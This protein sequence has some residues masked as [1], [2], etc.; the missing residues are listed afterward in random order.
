MSGRRIKDSEIICC[1]LQFLWINELAEWFFSHGFGIMVPG[2]GDRFLDFKEK[3]PC[4][5]RDFFV[6][7]LFICN[8]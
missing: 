1:G 2:I 5:C 7:N 4:Q 8:S 3:S 6:C